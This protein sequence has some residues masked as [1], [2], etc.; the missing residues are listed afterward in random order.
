[1]NSA[2]SL[3]RVAV[4]AAPTLAALLI[5]MGFFVDPAIEKSGREL[6]AEYAAHSH[7]EQV[8]ALAFH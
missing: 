2:S 1:M 4:I 7:R 6:A 8:S 5:V 3:R